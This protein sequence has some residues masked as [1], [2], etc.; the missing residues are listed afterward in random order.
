MHGVSFLL[1]PYGCWTIVT[2]ITTVAAM[3]GPFSVFNAVASV[4]AVPSVG[5]LALFASTV[6]IVS[7]EWTAFSV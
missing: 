5:S 2:S 3:S 6:G 7:A 4:F 1:C